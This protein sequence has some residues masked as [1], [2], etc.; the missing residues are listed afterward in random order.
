M[1]AELYLIHIGFLEDEEI[2][3]QRLKRVS[4]QRR[5]K[6]DACRGREDK[7]RS[8]AVGLLLEEQMRQNFMDPGLVEEEEG[9]KLI[10]PN[11][12]SFYFS[13]AHSGEYAACAVSDFPVGVDIQQYKAVR[14]GIAKRFFQ[15]DEAALLKRAKGDAREELFFRLWTGKES[16]V[17]LTG[18][19]LRKNLN[20]FCVD[21]EKGIIEDHSRPQQRAYL[22]EYRCLPEYAITL[23]GYE[24]DFGRFVKRIYYRL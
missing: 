14:E 1:A 15:A 21:L 11:Q 5:Q 20:S 13:L 4:R 3:A 22:R 12:T 7:L 24:D 8:L 2:F 16:Y 17:K 19:G 9:G 6:V 23:A 10:I 18:E